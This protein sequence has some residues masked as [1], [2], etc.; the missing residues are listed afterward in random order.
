MAERSLNT[1]RILI[2]DDEPANVDLLQFALKRMGYR[3][4]MAT[5]DPTRVTALFAEFDPDII[6]L[7]LHMPGLNGFEVMEQLSDLVSPDTYLPILVL[8]ADITPETKRRALAGGAKDFLVKPFDVDEVMLRIRNML[9]IRQ[10]HLRLQTQNEF[11]TSVSQ[12]ARAPLACLLEAALR[13]E[14]QAGSLSQA[15]RE[16]LIGDVVANANKLE[17]LLTNV[18][19]STA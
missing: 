5:I 3:E 14:Q 4:V 13:L 6:L 18:P 15:D 16:G 9:E 12:E 11:I 19:A 8:T 2:V 17:R 7:D 1:A 10:L